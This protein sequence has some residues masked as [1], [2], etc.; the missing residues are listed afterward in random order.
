MRCLAPDVL[1]FDELGGEDEVDA[2]TAGLFA[3]VAA[4]ASAHCRDRDSLL[5]RQAVRRALE[6]RAFDYV[7]M[8]AGRGAAGR[9]GGDF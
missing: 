1:L 9:G 6:N 5:R 4:I 3:G 7:V 2:V 8:L